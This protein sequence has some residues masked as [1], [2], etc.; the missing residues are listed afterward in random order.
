MTQTKPCSRCGQTKPLSDFHRCRARRDGRQ[1]YC[2]PCNVDAS[3]RWIRE[4]RDEQA[5]HSRNWRSSHPG[6][7]AVHKWLTRNY[8]KTG[9]CDDCGASGRTEWANISGLY[10]RDRRDYQEL[11]SRCHGAKDAERRALALN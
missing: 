11:C 6:Y 2:K 9:R 8:A 3:R 5:A 1:R 4:H 7:H 10:L